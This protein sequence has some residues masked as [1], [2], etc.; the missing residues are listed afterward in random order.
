MS[1]YEDLP[2]TKKVETAL[3]SIM[4]LIWIREGWGED[5]KRW[6][7]YSNEIDKGCE[8]ILEIVSSM[9]LENDEL[10][11]IE[12]EKTYDEQQISKH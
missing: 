11:G 2:L 9:E 12:K 6:E 7:Q 10:K 8:E 4:Y 5:S 3:N 1:K